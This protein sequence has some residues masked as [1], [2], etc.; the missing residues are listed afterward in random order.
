MD[1]VP[2]NVIWQKSKRLVQV[3]AAFDVTRLTGS[4][5]A[6]RVEAGGRSRRKEERGKISGDGLLLNGTWQWW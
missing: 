1:T 3:P 2:V 6:I 4:T 5:A